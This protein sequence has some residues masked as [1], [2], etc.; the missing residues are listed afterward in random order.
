MR[1]WSLACLALACAP[2]E[3]DGVNARRDEILGGAA[4][5]Q[6]TSVFFVISTFNNGQMGFCTGTLVSPRVI[7]TAAHCVDPA[8][9]GASSVMVRVMNEPDDRML[10]MSDLRNVVQVRRHPSYSGQ[11]AND[12][13]LLQLDVAVPGVTPEQLVRTPPGSWAGQPIRVV[14]YGRTSASGASDTGTRRV[15]NTTIARTMSETFEFGAAGSLG[16]CSGDSGGPS[17]W[18]GPDGRE[19]VAGVHSYGTTNQC[20]AGGDVRV[21]AELAFLDQTLNQL[22]PP[23]CGADGRCQL[24]CTP[25]DP[26]CTCL[27]DARCEA[28]PDGRVDPDCPADCVANG[29]CRSAGCPVVDPDCFLDGDVCSAANEC[30][31]DRCLD[32]PRGFRFCSRACTA[33]TM[34]Q[35]EMRC[36]DQ[37]CR[38]DPSAPRPMPMTPGA[39]DDVRGGCDATSDVGWAALSIVLLRRRRP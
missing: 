6:S 3:R 29:V 4:D 8:R 7:L 39:V 31:G 2:A 13:A 37:V 14:G 26:D 21:D 27:A 9:E 18:R 12:L 33:D 1:F 24:G 17:F 35:R 28:C 5:P 32:D 10:M 19:R 30:V 11:G 15:V 23:A 38:P 36:V 25:V 16:I 34:C 20:G 22:D